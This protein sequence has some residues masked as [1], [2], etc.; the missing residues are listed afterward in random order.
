MKPDTSYTNVLLTVI[1]AAVSVIAFNG[2]IRPKAEPQ[3]EVQ[4]SFDRDKQTLTLF[5]RKSG[6]WWVYQPAKEDAWHL[7]LVE[8]GEISTE[9]SKLGEWKTSILCNEPNLHSCAPIKQ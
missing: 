3:T 1:A 5:D 4:F 8:V 9:S 2:Y 7:A 6:R